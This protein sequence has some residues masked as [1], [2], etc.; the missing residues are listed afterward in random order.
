MQNHDSIVVQYPEEE[1]DEIIP[2]ILAQL[3]NRILLRY[4][5]TLT[6]PFG[7][8]TGWNWGDY[9]EGNPDGL[10]KYQPGDKRNRS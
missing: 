6:I 3:N 10:K 1:E 2:K 8:K 4:D 9:S 7:C 5:R